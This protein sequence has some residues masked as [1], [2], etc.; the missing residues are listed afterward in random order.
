MNLLSIT[1]FNVNPQ[2]TRRGK[3]FF[4]AAM[5]LLG[6]VALTVALLFMAQ[7]GPRSVAAQPQYPANYDA[8]GN[9]LIEITTLAQ[10]NAIRWDIDGN[11]VPDREADQY[12]GDTGAFPVSSDGSVCPTGKTC[13]G[14]E[15]MANLDFDTGSAG[16]RTDDTYHNAGA[17]W[18]PPNF[19]A[20][21]D[22]RGHTISN[23]FIN[24]AST[25][26][27]GFFGGLGADTTIKRLGLVDANVTASSARW[28]GGIAGVNFGTIK[29][30]YVTGKVGGGKEVGGLAGLNSRT[31]TVMA[32][33]STASVTSGDRGSVVGGIVGHNEGT[34]K[35]CYSTGNVEGRNVG[36]LV[37]SHSRGTI[38][39]SYATGTVGASSTSTSN[40]QSTER[41]SLSG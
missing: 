17:G 18:R 33:Y 28:V 16:D 12:T 29:T 39:A 6:A 10:L 30:S 40:P 5:I 32:S 8:N 22:G 15:L 1:P 26:S 24:A 38:T 19:N 2:G 37:G 41:M 3:P 23:L 11:G 35:A 25:T 21:F 34:I 31:A 4:L 14:Y 9:N 27:V 13:T 20:T 36:G 7:M